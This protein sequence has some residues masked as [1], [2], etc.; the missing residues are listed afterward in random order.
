MAEPYFRGSSA[1]H[2]VIKTKCKKTREMAKRAMDALISAV[3]GGK[4]EKLK[5]YLAM[6]AKFHRYSL[7]NVLLIALQRPDASRVAGYRTWQ[8]LGRQVRQGERGIQILAPIVRR[9]RDESKDKEDNE[10]E[11]LAFRTAHV[12]DIGQTDGRALTDFA[13]VQGDPGAYAERLKKIVRERNIQLEYSDAIGSADGLSGKGMIL[14]RKGLMPAEEF[15]VLVHE[16]AHAVLHCGQEPGS[17]SRTIRETEAEAVAFIVSQ[18]VG[19]DCNTASSDYVQLYQG[20]K[21]TLMQSL[22]QIQQTAADIIAGI[23]PSDAKMSKK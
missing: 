7:G 5:A 15:S 23:L 20:S 6:M 18:A 12:F 2:E 13:Q 3:E 8:H 9:R 11:V 17:K 22:E 1:W 16:L 10:E 19:L 14:L 4:S 21:E